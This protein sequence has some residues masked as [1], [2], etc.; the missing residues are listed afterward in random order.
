VVNDPNTPIA[1]KTL[2]SSL[3]IPVCSEKYI[4]KLK[5]KL[6]KKLTLSVPMG[7]VKAPL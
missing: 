7:K 5:T 4:I 1:K 6:P 3:S 2:T